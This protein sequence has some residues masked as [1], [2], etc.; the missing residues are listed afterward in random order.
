MTN[1]NFAKKSNISVTYV[2]TKLFR[3]A[4]IADKNDDNE[5]FS[6]QKRLEK[7]R[8]GVHKPGRNFQKPVKYFSA[9]LLGY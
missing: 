6:H 4:T 5:N 9:E 7:K 2:T 8:G 3:Q 1:E